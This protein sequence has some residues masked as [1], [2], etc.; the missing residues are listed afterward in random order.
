MAS[1]LRQVD[2]LLCPFWATWN[3]SACERV[4]RAIAAQ[5]SI[6]WRLRLVDGT[7]GAAEEMARSLIPADRLEYDLPLVRGVQQGTLYWQAMMSSRARYVAYA[8]ARAST[9]LLWRS[10]HLFILADLI[11]RG[12][13]DFVFSGP[14]SFGCDPDSIASIVAQREIVPLGTVMHRSDVYARLD[15][16]WDRFAPGD[17]EHKVWREMAMLR[18]PP[19]RMYHFAMQTA[20][21]PVLA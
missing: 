7:F 18:R 11:G 9:A 6:G 10:D 21:R 15:R 2:I 12:R 16:G 17:T 20:A 4:L 8:D 13:A 3:S 5:H 19:I 1:R 14:A